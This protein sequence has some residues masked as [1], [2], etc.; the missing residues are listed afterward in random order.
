[1]HKELFEQL[2]ELVAVPSPDANDVFSCALLFAHE[3][4]KR[5]PEN[6]D[7]VGLENSSLCD[8]PFFRD[9]VTVLSVFSEADRF[10]YQVSTTVMV[11][12]FAKADVPAEVD[13]DRRIWWKGRLTLRN[14]HICASLLIMMRRPKDLFE[15]TEEFVSTASLNDA[16]CGLYCVIFMTH[17]ARSRRPIFG[18]T[19]TIDPHLVDHQFRDLMHLTNKRILQELIPAP[20]KAKPDS[21]FR[22]AF[23]APDIVA[24]ATNTETKIFFD[25]AVTLLEMYKDIEIDIVS[26]GEFNA[27]GINRCLGYPVYHP[28]D[29]KKLLPKYNYNV[30]ADV[31]D[32][33]K[34][35]NTPKEIAKTSIVGAIQSIIDADYDCV[36]TTTLLRWVSIG[37]LNEFI[38]VVYLPIQLGSYPIYPIDVACYYDDDEQ[39]KLRTNVRD[40][41]DVGQLL[42]LPDSTDV[43]AN[44]QNEDPSKINL[45]T[46]GVDWDIRCP[47]GLEAFVAGMAKTLEAARDTIWTCVGI[48]DFRLANFLKTFPE[49]ATLR[50]KGRIEFIA[51][52][53]PLAEV[54][55]K[56]DICVVPPMSGGGRATVMCLSL[57]QA[58]VCYHN[59]DARP[60]LGADFIA[61]TDT[62]YFN[63]LADLIGDADMRALTG[64]QNR[65]RF[66]SAV[67]SSA[68][69]LL[70]ACRMAVANRD[71]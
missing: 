65:K 42:I 58:A 36:I 11:S 17:N 35:V 6:I 16:I 55:A 71:L 63:A 5:A 31:L 33:I 27:G 32:R 1:M 24:L 9:V 28:I 45:I 62:E 49:L 70:D 57:G 43:V 59:N 54:V 61:S 64:A 18:I 37:A 40:W 68:D 46:L 29:K 20:T 34:V 53:N 47:S 2:K 39:K 50:D 21:V 44:A 52:A 4:R 7:P 60:Y 14:Y 10:N 3:D 38:P 13:L 22:I 48:K 66:Q 56:G 67:Q 23:L 51:Y 26:V 19:G 25:Y 15:L 41:F 8:N 69:R 30:P 12:L